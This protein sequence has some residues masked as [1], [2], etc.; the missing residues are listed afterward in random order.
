MIKEKLLTASPVPPKFLTIA[1]PWG[2]RP[3][4]GYLPVLEAA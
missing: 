4:A 3:L 2:S 1:A